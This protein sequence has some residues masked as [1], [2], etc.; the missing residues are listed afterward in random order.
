MLPDNFDA[1]NACFR[2]TVINSA[3]TIQSAPIRTSKVTGVSFSC[4]GFWHKS[5]YSYDV[6]Y[7]TIL[8][9]VAKALCWLQL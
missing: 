4:S 2:D 8:T 9:L 1:L 6:S 3:F 5:N 7:S